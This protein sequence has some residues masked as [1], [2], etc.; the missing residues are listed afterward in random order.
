MINLSVVSLTVV[1]ESVVV[2]SLSEH[3]QR[4]NSRCRLCGARTKRLVKNKNIRIKLC[5]HYASDIYVFHNVN[6]LEDQE[7]K[8][9]KTMCVKC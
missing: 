1:A 8:H 2:L 7:G 5:A 4:V 6:V 9:S 3:I